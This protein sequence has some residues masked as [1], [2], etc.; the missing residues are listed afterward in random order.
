MSRLGESLKYVAP[1]ASQLGIS[2]EQTSAALGELFNSGLQ[3]S[4][5]GTSLRQGL[6]RLQAP[7]KAA[8]AAIKKLGIHY[9]DI[10][11]Q[12][13]DLVEIMK[14]FQKAGAG[15]IDKGDELAKIFGSRTVAAWQ[16]L[17]KNGAK[18]MAD[19]EE[20]ITGTNKA[21]EMAEIQ[22]NT[23]SGQWK[24]LKSVMQEAAIQMGEALQPILRSLVEIFQ[25]AFALF[26]HL[27]KSIKTITVAA[28]ALAAGLGLVV[29]PVALLVA[30]L[31]ALI[32]MVSTL[33]VSRS[34]ER[35]VGKECRSRWSPYH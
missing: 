29:G 2:I 20:K 1:I 10:N 34:E 35:R 18:S 17:I 8:T 11:P 6:I 19:L 14:A 13:H 27:P 15:M 9:D 16:I 22:L 3:A 31:P 28:L 23:F 30:Q 4:Q 21:A 5:A 33:G 32:A 26:N 24:I 12:M 25:D 7:T